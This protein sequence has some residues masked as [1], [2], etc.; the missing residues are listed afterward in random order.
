MPCL[1]VNDADIAQVCSALLFRL[2]P[3]LNAVVLRTSYRE[4]SKNFQIAWLRSC[5]VVVRTIWALPSRNC[6]RTFAN[7]ARL[8]F[9]MRSCM[10]LACPW[11][12]ELISLHREANLSHLMPVV[13][14]VVDGFLDRLPLGSCPSSPPVAEAAFRRRRVQHHGV[15]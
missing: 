9:S 5:T 3:C 12:C 1:F 6:G 14:D 7:V 8:C 10:F 4:T 15:V 11:L 2:L 13:H